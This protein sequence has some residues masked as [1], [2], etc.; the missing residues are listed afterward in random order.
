[1]GAGQGVARGGRYR[2]CSFVA[3]RRR[4][5]RR[6]PRPLSTRSFFFSL[7][8]PQA[9]SP[10]PTWR[11]PTCPATGALTPCAWAPTPR[12]W[13]GECGDGW[14]GL[15]RARAR[16]RPRDE[17][18]PGGE[19]VGGERV[20]G[21]G[22]V[23]AA[24]FWFFGRGVPCLRGARR[25]AG[26][27]P[28]RPHSAVTGG[29]V[30]VPS[31]TPGGVAGRPRAPPPR[32]LRP[33]AQFFAR[34]FLWGAPTLTL[35]PRYHPSPSFQVPPGRAGPLPVGHAG[36]GRHPGPGGQ[37]SSKSA[38][39]ERPCEAA[40]RAPGGRGHLEPALILRHDS[41]SLAH[42]HPLCP[43]PH[44]SP[45]A[46]SIRSSSP[47]SSSTTPPC[48]RTSPNPCSSA[49]PPAS[50]TTAACWPGSSCSCTLWRSAAG[51]MS[52]S[53]APSTTTPSSRATGCPTRSRA[54][55]AGRSTRSALPRATSS[56]CRP[57]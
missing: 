21:G 47:T 15:G 2:S 9:P 36:R 44:P 46:P 26:G 17:G 49:G 55:R 7:S 10:R 8:L 50:S 45:L 51:W 31:N 56:P 52:R 5:P 25:P 38:G 6:R 27:P 35:R 1:M 42:P 28:T 57:R 22:R 24:R 12:P 29:P 39:G 3:A 48:P 34:P 32:A 43:P 23:L 53:T 13:P 11:P 37:F 33:R 41:L 30:D 54:T 20:G 16:G 4:S 40:G 19:R 18:N 14:R